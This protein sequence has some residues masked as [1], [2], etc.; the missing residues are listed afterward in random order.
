MTWTCG[1]LFLGHDLPRW[2]LGW[3][4]AEVKDSPLLCVHYLDDYIKVVIYEFNEKV[5]VIIMSSH[6]EDG[7]E[8]REETSSAH[9][10]G[11]RAYA[12]GRSAYRT[13]LYFTTLPTLSPV[14]DH[15]AMVIPASLQ[16]FITSQ[17]HAVY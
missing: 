12:V 1:V 11:F 3:A 2:M 16:I 8:L 4:S 14:S 17:S 6:S 13:I 15:T 7:M 9:H 5:G 10:G